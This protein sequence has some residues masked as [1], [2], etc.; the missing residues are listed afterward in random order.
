MDLGASHGIRLRFDGG[1]L[2]AVLL[3]V[4]RKPPLPVAEHFLGA[5]V[6]VEPWP[7]A[8]IPLTRVTQRLGVG[9]REL[10]L[11]ETRE[12]EVAAIL[13]QRFDLHAPVDWRLFLDGTPTP[14]DG[15]AVYALPDLTI[16]I[17]T[18]APCSVDRG[19]VLVSLPEG[20]TELTVT[21]K[22]VPVFDVSDTVV[23]CRPDQVREAAIVASCLPGDR[24]IPI[25]PVEPPPI[26]QAEYVARYTE[27]HR[28]QERSMSKVG[29]AIGRS[30]VVSGDDATLRAAIAEFAH[31]D[32]L[33]R[34]LSAYR[35]W[36]KHN[37]LV[38]ALITQMGVRRAVLLHDFGPE[39]LNIRDPALAA[40]AHEQWVA[41]TGQD[42]GDPFNNMLG[43]VP[44][45][46]RL[47]GTALTD[48]TAEAWRLLRGDAE[49]PPTIDVPLD[50]G[51]C[52]AAL[53][54]ALRTGRVLRAVDGAAPVDF[55]EVNPDSDEAVLVENT[56]DP[57]ALVGA[58]YAH[59][60]SARL[61]IT[62]P[63]DL[64]PVRAAVAAQQDKV[65][66]ASRDADESRGLRR[67]FGWSRN[68]YEAVEA[69]VTAQVPA[70][71]VAE[72][73]DRRL[74][75]FTT[76]LPYA[77]VRTADADWARK[78]IGHI[79]ADPALMILNELYS[80]GVARSPGAFSLV[81]DPGFFRVSETE[82][83]LRSVS[84]HFTHP[85]RVTAPDDVTL[86]ALM[87]LPRDLPV[88]LVFFNTHGS[89][90][91]IVLGRSLVLHEWLIPQWLNLEHRPIVFNNSCQ[92][93]TGVG[94]QFVRVGA[95]GYIGTLWS[96]PSKEAAEFGR[97]VVDRLTAGEQRACESIV[98]TGA[99]VERSYLYVGT[100]NGRLDQWRDRASTPAEAALAECALLVEAANTSRVA[101]ALRHEIATLRRVAEGTP[102][103]DT[104][105]YAD[106][107]LTELRFASDDDE[108]DDT[109]PQLIDRVLDRLD[110]PA[111]ELDSRRA[112]RF[113]LTGY[114][115]ERRGAPA[116]AWADYERSLAL[117]GEV[118]LDM[119]DLRMRQ[120]DIGAAE[121]LAQAAYDRSTEAGDKDGVMRA[122]GV[123]G[124][125]AKRRHDHPEAMR[126]AQEGHTRA[127]EQRNER[128]QGG[129]KL[130]Q[131]ILHQLMGDLDAAIAAGTE[132]LA[133]FRAMHDD[134]AELA[135]VGRLGM[136][137]RARGDLA[138][139]ER[140]AMTGLAQ[141]QRM[142]GP[143]QLAAFHYDV[144][145]VLQLRDRPTEALAH[146]R[147]A[148]QL[149][150][151]RGAWE[152]AAGF[153]DAFARC[154]AGL[155][156]ADALWTAVVW[157]SRICASAQ[158]RLWSLVVPVVVEAAKVA[159]DCGRPATTN[160][161][162]TEFAALVDTQDPDL[163]PPPVRLLGEVSA[164][165]RLWLTGTAD[166]V[167]IGL[168]QYVDSKTGGALEL[169][170]FV[171]VP[172]A[173]R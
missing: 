88:E 124:Q 57:A 15:G 22:S 44:Q 59:H 23:V 99:A 142:G 105:A 92:S 128:E 33:R 131:C 53:F 49:Q 154:A 64:A 153:L 35:S 3:D 45:S 75:A 132:A 81:F 76:G 135:A 130:D 169:A 4:H 158:E 101:G 9:T 5:G 36:L 50:A 164:L 129:F 141:A 143:A 20:A 137:H 94:R 62:P 48:L 151:D 69:A 65:T 51:N 148:A 42:D 147:A 110:L 166:P 21:A 40:E 37:N 122:I 18:T 108:P 31:T 113:E 90:D 140:Y 173:R 103:A 120:G 52:V 25:I 1:R 168:A 72:V 55:A 27:F 116:E 16:S 138:A 155:G 10:D 6:D 150:V 134:S 43:G 127:V 30:E 112:T 98:D 106:I 161:G 54:V 61:V 66:A 29:G 70:A 115:H 165:L 58:V 56:A 89:D 152:L 7:S 121:E 11:A 85:I 87:T 123:L 145:V 79:A 126:L 67:I 171:A 63:P 47:S 163:V 111:D 8:E 41:L 78:P 118:E 95:R 24:F 133:V 100:A 160:R 77:F 102:H 109:L 82:D 97:I 167:V 73:G 84:G 93:W 172:Y 125:L 38:A 157:G 80:V 86:D 46:L 17:E 26:T 104:V 2:N 12:I 159:I 68:P 60:R 74:T 170:D 96:I 162:L 13:R 107:L 19:G 39:D 156:D 28:V 114:M 91:G 14:V 83:V 144:G 71:A 32:A 34:S 119:A 146:H 149:M 139:A 136:C 117:G